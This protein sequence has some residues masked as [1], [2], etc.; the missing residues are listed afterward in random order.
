MSQS[1]SAENG[2]VGMTHW[3]LWGRRKMHNPS[4]SCITGGRFVATCSSELCLRA[5][6]KVRDQQLHRESL[7]VHTSEGLQGFHQAT[8]N[9]CHTHTHTLPVCPVVAIIWGH[10]GL[11]NVP[12]FLLRHVTTVVW[13]ESGVSASLSV[14]SEFMCVPVSER[15]WKETKKN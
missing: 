5:A 7:S 11:H 12:F 6:M 8:M 3:V 2:V 4:A 13:A 14:Q 10:T 9:Y 1:C 15:I